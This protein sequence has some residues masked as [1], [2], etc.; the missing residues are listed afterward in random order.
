MTGNMNIVIAGLQ[1]VIGEEMFE[2]K[3]KSVEVAVTSSQLFKYT[4]PLMEVQGEEKEEVKEPVK[5]NVP[6]DGH[7]IYIKTLKGDTVTLDVELSFTIE[8]I[9]AMLEEKEGIPP[10]Q[11]RLIFAGKEMDSSRSLS[12][13]N[14]Q[15]ESVLH[16]VLKF[17]YGYTTVYHIQKKFFDPR[18]DFDFRDIED[19]NETYIRGGKIYTRPIGAMRYAI[20]IMGNYPSTKWLG[21]TG[22]SEEEWPVAYFGT[23][24]N[25]YPQIT[26]HG[27]DLANC[28]KFVHKRGIY[29]TPDPETARQYA[30]EFTYEG[31]TYRLIFQARV[32]PKQMV[33]V[34]EAEDNGHGEYWLLPDGENIRPYGICVYDN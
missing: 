11:Q 16:M 14:I 23:E 13:Y 20:R 12:D 28:Q 19:E 22:E 32:N 10:G 17:R 25:K 24:E 33:V 2:P 27:F 26:R 18:Y 9:K 31:E 1:A 6:D 34:K 29:C 3:E 15:K 8:Q 5:I 21:S 30:K 7:K 4:Y